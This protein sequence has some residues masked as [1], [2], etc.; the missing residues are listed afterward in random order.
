MET[1][2]SLQDSAVLRHNAHIDHPEDGVNVLLR[3]E[4]FLQ[5][6]ECHVLRIGRRHL[7]H[8]LPNDWRQQC[9]DGVHWLHP[10]QM[11]AEEQPNNG[12]EV[13]G[14]TCSLEFSVAGLHHQ[15]KWTVR[16]LALGA[17]MEEGGVVS[18]QVLHQ[19]EPRAD[20]SN[21][22]H[23]HTVYTGLSTEQFL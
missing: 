10:N 1:Y 14:D 4:P 6:F 19:M 22:I 13:Q 3:G 12:G 7:H 18:L 9:A 16:V 5:D 20:P 15:V 2:L 17:L 11:D 8:V 21:G 23:L